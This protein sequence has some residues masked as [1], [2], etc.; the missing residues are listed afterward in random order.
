MARERILPVKGLSDKRRTGGDRL[1]EEQFTAAVEAYGD[2]L[3][4]IAFSWCKNR[5]DAEDMVQSAF[6]KFLRAGRHFDGEE[7]VRR[8]LIRVTVNN[9]KKLMLSPWR[10]RCEPLEDVAGDLYADQP[11]DSELFLAVMSLPQK[12]RVAVH[13]YYYEGYSVREISRLLRTNE[14]TIQSRL[15]SARKNLKSKLKEAWTSDE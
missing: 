5:P 15:A 7:H 12:Q 3:Y 1:T 4:R 10:T 14:S 2:M 11:E 9:C 6:V 8:W 13:L